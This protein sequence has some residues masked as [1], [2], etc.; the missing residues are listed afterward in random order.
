MQAEI[1]LGLLALAVVVRLLL[2]ACEVPSTSLVPELTRDYD[3][4]TTLFR[5]RFLSGWTGGLI[6][7]F[8]A[9]QVF[10]ADSLLEPE[11]YA[12]YAGTNASG[13]FLRAG[14]GVVNVSS[15]TLQTASI[16][17]QEHI[18]RAVF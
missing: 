6:M 4:R 1:R 3:E 8:L 2:S 7:L 12:I 11:G 15:G 14:S 13:T 5:Y 16:N 18:G 10:L 17:G 9:Y